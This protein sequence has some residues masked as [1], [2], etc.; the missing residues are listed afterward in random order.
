MYTCTSGQNDVG[1][2]GLGHNETVGD[3]SNEM[4]DNLEVVQ[5]GDNFTPSQVV[6]GLQFNCA[7][8]NQSAIK[9]WGKLYSFYLFVFGVI[10][11]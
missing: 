3:E 9:C 4:G 10:F 7:L 11:I 6:A 5:L 8:S 2:L 1:Q